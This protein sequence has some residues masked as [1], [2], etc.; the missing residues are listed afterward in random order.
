MDLPFWDSLTCL[1]YFNFQLQNKFFAWDPWSKV[2]KFTPDAGQ[3]I[4]SRHIYG[5][6]PRWR[7]SRR[8]I[9][10]LRKYKDIFL[11]CFLVIHF[12]PELLPVSG[13]C[14]WWCATLAGRSPAI[15][16]RV[17]TAWALYLDL[18]WGPCQ[19]GSSSHW[20]FV[21]EFVVVGFSSL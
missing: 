3:K 4:R 2:D 11:V 20:I 17:G 10:Y 1:K 21:V 13:P 5:H 7:R 12:P 16:L 9:Y 15:R 6:G 18:S 19:L 14:T 8:G